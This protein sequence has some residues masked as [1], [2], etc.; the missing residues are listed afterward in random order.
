[1]PKHPQRSFFRNISQ[2]QKNFLYPILVSCMLGCIITLLILDYLYFD[3]GSII[4]EY[5]FTKLKI[6]ILIGCVL[7]S[8][9]LFFITLAMYFVSNKIVG[10][11]DRIIGELDKVLKGEFKG[12]LNV[13]KGDRLFKGL[14][15]RINA[16][17]ER[18]S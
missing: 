14:L 11:Y 15:D 4:Y 13:R 8:L 5:E 2:T 9:T 1:M 6:I 17:I 7:F 12:P 18:I 3:R 16:L 10:P